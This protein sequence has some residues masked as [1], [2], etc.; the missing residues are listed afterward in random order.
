[1]TRTTW[2]IP[3]GAL[4]LVL[5]LM[6]VARG[7]IADPVDSYSA[8]SL[9]NL[10]NAYA[11]QG[12]PALA[13]L[14]YERARLLAPRDP[15]IKANLLHERQAASLPSPP[16]RFD[17]YV[18]LL[19]PDATYWVG[20]AGLVISGICGLLLALR[21]SPRLIWR[22][23]LAGG[24]L[25]MAFTLSDA[26]ATARLMRTAVVMQSASAS[27]SP[28]LNA[29]TL[30]TLAPATLVQIKDQ[31]GNFMLIQ[32]SEGRVGWVPRGQITTIVATEGQF[33]A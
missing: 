9:Y 13:I 28:I 14:N 30:F 20:L 25:M 29:E 18:R 10:G 33:H 1:M 17:D 32:D 5:S 3:C 11:R 15:D 8:A 2:N 16:P 23:A 21:K 31:H 26:T 4:L 27:A 22:G 12:K 19:S 24:L 6:G 7:A